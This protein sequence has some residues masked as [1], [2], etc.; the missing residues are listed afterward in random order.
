MRE[1]QLWLAIGNK[2]I[3]CNPQPSGPRIGKQT[4]EKA[5]PNKP[6]NPLTLKPQVAIDSIERFRAAI[7][8]VQGSNF[9]KLE[10]GSSKGFR[11]GFRL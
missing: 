10:Y 1:P 8:I 3:Y 11:L 5:P 2:A 9:K 6:L 4:M 7:D